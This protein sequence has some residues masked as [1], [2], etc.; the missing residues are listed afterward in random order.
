MSTVRL[1]NVAAAAWIAG[2]GLIAAPA[3]PAQP[4]S[5]PGGHS[6]AHAEVRST[7]LGSGGGEVHLFEPAAPAPDQAP[8][9]VFVHGWAGMDPEIYGGWIT[10]IVRRGFTVIAPRY[11]A[12]IRTPVR[13]FDRNALE[14]TRRALETLH[15]AGHVAPDPR[16]IVIVGH[17]MGG[18]ISANLAAHAAAGELPP[19]LALMSVA[20]GRTWPSGSPIAF[21]LADLSRLPS[22]LLL[23]TVAGNDDELVGDID[24]RR[25]YV[26]ATGVPPENKNFV[27]LFSDDH[28]APGLVADHR[29]PTAPGTLDGLD[30]APHLNLW[31]RP[32][33][34]DGARRSR[35]PMVVDAL[36]YFG[37]WKLLDGLVDAV[38]RGVHRE[39]ALGNTPQQRFMGVWSDGVPV[40][41]LHVEVPPSQD[42]PHAVEA[43]RARR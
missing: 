1:L 21:P 37:T 3:P 23:L 17:S 33:G 22:S 34:L 41:Q 38:F 30:E 35:G 8:V 7:R 43:T 32:D 11:Q 28:G 20:P 6:Y 31:Q 10:H 27:R 26:E 42:A 12:D 19:V 39:Y 13:Q 9:V 18:L 40:R 14:A 29:A 4:A 24:A 36:D 15:S 2:A 5:G 16:G 25:I